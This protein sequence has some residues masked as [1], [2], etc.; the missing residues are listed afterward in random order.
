MIWFML[1]SSEDD[2]KQERHGGSFSNIQEIYNKISDYTQRVI[3]SWC[4]NGRKFGIKRI[5][6]FYQIGIPWLGC[7]TEN[8][9]LQW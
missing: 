2:Q 8:I 1:H 7:K 6:I 3:S 5:S 9:P 4:Q